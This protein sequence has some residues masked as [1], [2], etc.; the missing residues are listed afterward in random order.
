MAVLGRSVGSS[1]TSSRP[2]ELL[3]VPIALI[4]TATRST[5]YL[6]G[7]PA[8]LHSSSTTHDDARAARTRMERRRLPPTLFIHPT[9]GG[10]TRSAATHSSP[11]RVLL[12]SRARVSRTTE[13]T[14]RSGTCRIFSRWRRARRTSSTR[15]HS[16]VRSPSCTRRRW[17][18]PYVISSAAWAQPLLPASRS[19]TRAAR[20]SLDPGRR[21]HG[22]CSSLH[23]V[24]GC[25]GAVLVDDEPRG[26]SVS[27]R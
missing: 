3:G 16:T 19:R 25:A 26:R 13:R 24:R 17:V 22:L 8:R 11:Q 7:R 1:S 14:D 9:P 5:V 15:A 18:H 21:H 23:L 27:T 4:T 20:A 10:A 6:N 12:L 2:N